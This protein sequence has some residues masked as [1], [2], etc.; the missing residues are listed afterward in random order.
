[1][2]NRAKIDKKT[3][4]FFIFFHSGDKVLIHRGKKGAGR[5]GAKSW[6]AT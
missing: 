1:L 2:N 6:T 5:G 3:K 4:S